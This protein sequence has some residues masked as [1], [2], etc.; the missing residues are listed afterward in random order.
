MAKSYYQQV[1]NMSVQE[2][3]Q[4]LNLINI[5]QSHDRIVGRNSIT[6]ADE[7]RANYTYGR[8]MEIANYIDYGHWEDIPK[9]IGQQKKEIVT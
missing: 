7:I 2:L 9:V 5:K 8:L 4:C 3:V 1:Q 6:K